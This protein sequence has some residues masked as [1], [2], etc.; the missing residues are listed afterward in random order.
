LASLTLREKDGARVFQV[1]FT[2]P[3]AGAPFQCLGEWVLES[4]GVM[5]R[6]T[7]LSL[8]FHPTS[9]EFQARL[10]GLVRGGPLEASL[11]DFGEAGAKQPPVV[12]YDGDATVLARIPMRLLNLELLERY[13]Q[14]GPE[15]FDFAHY[16][17]SGIEFLSGSAFSEG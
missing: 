13:L 14:G 1:P 10:P 8:H 7:R 15:L 16:R 4:T 12:V 6:P 11:F 2:E 9:L 3:L 17:F 5:A